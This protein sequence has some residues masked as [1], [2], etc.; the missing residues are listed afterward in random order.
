MMAEE[1]PLWNDMK[2]FFVGDLARERDGLVSLEPYRP[3]R[4]PVVLVHGTFSSVRFGRGRERSDGGCRDSPTLPVL[5][6]DYNTGNPIVYSASLLRNAMEDLIDSLDPEGRDPA[7][8]R[9]IVVGHS[10]GGLLTK[11][12]AV[13]SGERFWR[14]LSDA[15]PRRPT[16]IPRTGRSSRLRSSSSRY[17]W[18][19]ASCSSRPP[20]AAASSRTGTSPADRSLRD[21][22]TIA[23]AALDLVTDDVEDKRVVS[24]P[25]RRAR[26]KTCP[27]ATGSLR[28]R[29]DPHRRPHPPSLDH[30][31]PGRA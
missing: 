20:I 3:G 24:S 18:S 6:F 4:I 31:G 1:N 17:R 12:M 27:R 22:L 26:S 8:R 25:G 13:H 16:S 11:L 2:R 7:L 19:S 28:A 29:R 30:R 21:P 5:A 15:S 14:L 10:Q 23:D 9:A